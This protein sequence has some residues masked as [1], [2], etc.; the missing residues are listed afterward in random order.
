MVPNIPNMMGKVKF[1]GTKDFQT[2]PNQLVALL[3][4]TLD[5][6]NSQPQRNSHRSSMLRQL[7]LPK[8]RC[9]HTCTASTG[10]A[11]QGHAGLS[12]GYLKVFGISLFSP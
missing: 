9:G 10:T 5:V 4:E 6:V 2:F 3:F 8:A 11:Y 12:C 7:G 1:H